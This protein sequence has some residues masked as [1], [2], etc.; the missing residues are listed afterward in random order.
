VPSIVLSMAPGIL[1]RPIVIVGDLWFGLAGI[2][3]ALTVSE[4]L[5]LLVGG[6]TWF[7]PLPRPRPRGRHRGAGGRG[8]R[9]G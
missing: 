7:P 5:V 6:V 8:A 3:W 9:T 4:V 1:F 2:V